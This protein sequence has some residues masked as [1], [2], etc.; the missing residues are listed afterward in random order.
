MN[1]NLDKING[2]EVI[3]KTMCLKLSWVV[4]VLILFFLSFIT[5]YTLKIKNLHYYSHIYFY[6]YIHFAVTTACSTNNTHV[7]TSRDDY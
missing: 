6:D 7:E 3:N 1:I 2:D 4:V 5:I